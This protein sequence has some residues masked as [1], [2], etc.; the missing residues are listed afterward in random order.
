MIVADNMIFPGG[1]NLVRYAKAV[2][3]KPKMTSVL[4]PVGSGLEISRFD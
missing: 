2:R 4:V 3:A 1:E